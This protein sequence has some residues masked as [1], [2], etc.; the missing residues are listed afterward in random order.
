MPHVENHSDDIPRFEPWLG[1]MMTSVVPV[2]ASM[3]LP[4]VLVPL[5]ALSAALF[6]AGLIMLRVQ[7]SRRQKT[8]G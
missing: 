8:M 6:A 4:R 2:A 1:V 5:L 3:Y 7:T